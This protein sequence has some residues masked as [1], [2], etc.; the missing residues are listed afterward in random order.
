M[1][2]GIERGGF[3]GVLIALIGL[4]W[5]ASAAAQTSLFQADAPLD[6]VIEAPLTTLIRTAPRNTDPHPATLRVGDAAPIPFQLSARGLTRRTAGFCNF[7]PLRLD[8]RGAPRRGTIFQG[9]ERLKLTTHCRAQ[10]A[11]E[12][13]IVVEYLAYRLYNA[14]TPLSFR[15]RPV[16]VTYRDTEGRRAEETRFGFLVEDIDDLARRN[17]TVEREAPSIAPSEL[18]AE[19]ATRAALFQYMIGNLDWSFVRGPAGEDCCHNARPV[20]APGARVT[21]VPY[22]FDHSGLVDAPYATVPQGVNAATVRSRVYRGL[23]IHNASVPAVAAAYRAKRDEV[24]AL[25]AGEERLPPARREAAQRYLAGFFDILNDAPRFTAL[26]ARTC[27]GD[28]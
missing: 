4:L 21:P 27:R 11:A 5:P 20:G 19:A 14:V 9:Q 12:Q 13:R 2:P 8:L 1:R 17:G 10:D 26:V 18:D 22:D 28:N 6:L 3:A 15:V 25:V 7:P 23:C 24:M 16:R